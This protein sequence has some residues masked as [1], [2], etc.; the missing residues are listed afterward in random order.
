MTW[1]TRRRL[2]ALVVVLSILLLAQMG[3][4]LLRRY[5][6]GRMASEVHR[7]SGGEAHAHVEG[8][9]AAWSVLRDDYGTITGGAQDVRVTVRGHE[10][11]ADVDVVA[12]DVTGLARG[13][14]HV[15][16]ATGRVDT[17]WEDLSE[18]TGVQ[19]SG[20]DDGLLTITT[21]VDA[22]G[23]R[24]PVRVTGRP[25]VDGATGQLGL[26]DA[27]ASL[28]TVDVPR[29]VVE[30]LLPRVATYAYLPVVD[31]V[32]WTGV[33]VGADGAQLDF[34]ADDADLPQW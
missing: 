17:T 32:T 1:L 34:R 2:I 19:L 5:V 20:S 22:L 16:D 13:P 9:P 29:D 24:L 10:V 33:Q 30:G 14:V 27:E 28:D 3:D 8:W 4:G 7:T 11:E 6:E 18:A 21:E 12:H 26:R 23:E 31:G 25:V 15:G